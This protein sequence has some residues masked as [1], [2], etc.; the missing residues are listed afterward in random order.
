MT[1]GVEVEDLRVSYGITSLRDRRELR[2]Q[3]NPQELHEHY[4]RGDFDALGGLSFTLEGG[5]IYGL[6]GRNGAG[7]TT[8]LSVLA[9][10]RRP[11]AGRVLI[12]GEPVFENPRITSQICLV[13]AIEI[14]TSRPVVVSVEDALAFASQL[15][16]HWD[17][18]Y[19]AALLDR[20]AL[21]RNTAIKT[22]SRGAQAALQIVLGLASRAPVTLFDEP[23]LGLDVAMRRKFYEELL[24]DFI[25]QPRTII[26]STHL[27]EEVSALFEEVVVID[28]GRLVVHD[29]A[30]DLRAR[31]A[32]VTGPAEAVDRFVNGLKVF[33][34]K[35]LGPTKSVMVYGGLD[36]ARRAQA[37]TAGIEL[38]PVALE[39]LFVHLTEPIGEP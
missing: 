32:A 3:H 28:R 27:I 30:E 21:D 9:A 39:E 11:T 10:Y 34:E 38:G 37:R 25:E 17:A 33:G 2:Q 13:G 6:L 22:L 4:K 1:L 19:A 35:R 16:P 36:D 29:D 15:R 7:K 18:D 24:A 23:H 20:F 31:G 8:L 5:K 12:G 14:S 26:L